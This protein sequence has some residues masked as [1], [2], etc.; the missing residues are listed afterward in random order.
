MFRLI[1]GEQLENEIKGNIHDEYWD[2][3][4]PELAKIHTLVEE[5]SVPWVSFYFRDGRGWNAMGYNSKG[6]ELY[7]NSIM[8]EK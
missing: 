7:G 6:W 4:D 8:S 5:G 1:W 3:K 2:F